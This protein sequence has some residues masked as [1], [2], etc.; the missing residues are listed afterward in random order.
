MDSIMFLGFGIDAWITIVTVLG[1]FSVLLFTKLRSDLVFLIAIGI[2]FVTGVLDAKEA[3]SGFSAPSVVTIGVLFVVV[4]GLTH[5]GVLHW[6][7]KNLLGQP[8]SYSKAVT[9]LML[10]VA[11]LSSFLSNTTV[12][13]LF[14]NIVKMWSKKLNI[15]PSKLLIP[16]SYASGMGGVCTL[17]GTP[18]NMIISGLYA[19]KTGVSMNVLATAIPGLF[20]L[21]IGVLSVIAMR[22]LLP[23]RQAPESDFEDTVDYTVEMLV[24]SNNPNIAKR[25]GKVGLLNVEGGKLIRWHHFDDAPVPINENEFIMGGDRLVFAG[26]IKDILELTKTHGLVVGAEVL[27]IGPKTM[28]STVIMTAMVVVA[29]LGIMPLLQCAFIAAAA[30]LLF[31]CCSPNQA[32]R[33]INWDILMVF[34]A[35]VVLGIAIQKTGIAEQLALG[36]LDVCGTNPLVVMTAICLVGTFATEFIS[37]TA[38]GAMFF[39]IMYEAAEKLGYEPYPFLIALMVSVSS[40]FAT[41]IGSPTH[42]LVY[43]PGGYRFSDFMRIGLLMNIIILAANIFI[44]N[45]VYPLTPLQ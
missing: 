23:N 44:V 20:C 4:A 8:G 17:I 41:P 42:M 29:A 1:M 6:I 24:P 27:N 21:A 30:M 43:G 3:F 34:A 26:K 2:L 16:L 14:V 18:P 5:T 19:D 10:P 15:S 31:R 33:S 37:N 36:I 35:S 13:A 12:V 9:R 38:A 28:V 32:M 22:R 39:P 11:V 45:I 40:S 25:I 7:V